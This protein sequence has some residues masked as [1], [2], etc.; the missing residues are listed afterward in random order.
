MQITR[1]GA[2]RPVFE[3]V[4]REM[5]HLGYPAAHWNWKL[6]R[7]RYT[8]CRTRWRQWL[9]A[10]RSGTGPDAEGRMQAP[11]EVWHHLLMKDPT[12]S[13]L[14]VEPLKNIDAWS[15]V[16]AAESVT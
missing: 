14:Q 15:E 9:R 11:E 2:L 10:E 3:R 1:A 6:V 16:F 5:I 12:G 7:K 8:D 13:W 4:A